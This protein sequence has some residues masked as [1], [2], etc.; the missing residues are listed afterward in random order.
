MTSTIERTELPVDDYPMWISGKP[1]EA[2]SGSWRDNVDPYTGK[3]W[4]R[5]AEGGAAEVDRAVADARHALEVGPWATMNGKRRGELMFELGRLLR[6]DALKIAELETRDNGKILR[7]SLRL[8]T[9]AAGWYEYFGGWA[10][11]LQ[12]D[13]IPLD[14]PS[15][16]VYTRREPVGVVAALTAWNSPLLLAAYKLGPGL[17]AGCTFVIKPSEDAPLSTLAFA[18]L[19]SEAGFPDGVVNVV[20]GDGPNVGEPLVSHPGVD[21]VAFTGSTATGIKVAQSAASHLA[22]VMLELGG[23]SPQIVFEDADLDAAA[24]GIAGGIFGSSGQSCTAGS[25]LFVHRDVADDLRARVVEAATALRLGDPLDETTAMGPLSFE[26]QMN[27]VLGFVERSRAAGAEVLTGGVR[28]DRPDLADGFFVEPTILDRVSNDDEPMR[29]EIFGPVLSMVT[30]EDDDEV[31]AA[32]N[33]NAYGL[34]SGIWTENIAR[35]HRA[36]HRMKAGTAWVN[37]YRLVNQA[38]PFGGWKASGYGVESGADSIREFT[39][40][41]VVWVNTARHG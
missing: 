17:A 24:A 22:P 8:A 35:A 31:I 23:K 25:R 18:R 19:V 14:D 37:T 20:T 29:E 21:K 30:F 34:A 36:A 11:K 5:V 9:L 33:S 1:A 38:V 40:S 3:V 12:G 7:E 39:R 15:M 2:S 16:L 26:T 41:K 27:R 28:S 32:A 10:D 13:T 4:A 6:R